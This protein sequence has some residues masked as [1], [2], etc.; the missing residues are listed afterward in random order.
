MYPRFIDKA[1]RNIFAYILSFCI[2][3]ICIIRI[4]NYNTITSFTVSVLREPRSRGIRTAF[5]RIFFPS[6]EEHP[7]FMQKERDALIGRLTSAYN[8]V[9][10]S[11]PRNYVAKFTPA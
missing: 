2:P 4:E 9:N 6:R 10:G 7:G 5:A 1:A 3:E 11:S 8:I